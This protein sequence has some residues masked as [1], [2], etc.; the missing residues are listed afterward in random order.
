M[1][2]ENSAF[3]KT[4]TSHFHIVINILVFQ[5]S[6]LAKRKQAT[7]V[8]NIYWLKLFVLPVFSRYRAPGYKSQTGSKEFHRGLKTMTT[9][10]A[11]G[12]GRIL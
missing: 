11:T 8:V 6:S 12:H 7:H 1:N 9:A 5:Y 2:G 10:C 3:R 4:L